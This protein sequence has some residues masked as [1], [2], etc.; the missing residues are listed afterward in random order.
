MQA[1]TLPVTREVI[2]VDDNRN[3]HY[4][5]FVRLR[6]ALT[7]CDID[8]AKTVALNIVYNESNT[9][10]WKSCGSARINFC[11]SA[12]AVMSTKGTKRFLQETM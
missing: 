6:S 2:P 11:M 10:V 9:H 1:E 12:T 7:N 5:M 4:R 3:K 8:N